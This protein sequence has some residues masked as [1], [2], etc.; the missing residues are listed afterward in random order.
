M[1]DSEQKQE[2]TKT[3]LGCSIALWGTVALVAILLVVLMIDMPSYKRQRQQ[4]FQN[5]MQRD[6]DTWTDGEKREFNAF[7]EWNK[8]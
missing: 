4:S 6:P 3:P 1:N 7:W 8:K 5:Q 2:K